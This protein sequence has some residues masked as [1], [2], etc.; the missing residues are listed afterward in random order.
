MTISMLWSSIVAG[1]QSIEANATGHQ[2]EKTLGSVA[3]IQQAAQFFAVASS[4]EEEKSG[5]SQS[6]PDETQ[7]NR[8]L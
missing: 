2:V 4:P 1:N 3:S 7:V 8:R 5:V 6:D